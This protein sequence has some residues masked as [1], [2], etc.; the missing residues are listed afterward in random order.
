MTDFWPGDL[1]LNDTQSPEQILNEAQHDWDSGSKGLLA[2]LLQPAT[3]KSGNSMIIVHAKH[4]P[5]RRTATLFTVVYR[6]EKPYPATIQPKG[7]E[8]PSFLK[9]SRETGFGAIGATMQAAVEA[10]T[11][12]WVSETPSEFRT[13]LREVLNLGTVKS[14]VLNLL[15]ETTEPDADEE[16]DS[17]NSV[18]E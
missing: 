9:K 13:K 6:P 15:V 14:E 11:N 18:D 7:E 16:A 12:P 3:S 1:D 4:V 17:S 8:I 5:S 2:L 10:A